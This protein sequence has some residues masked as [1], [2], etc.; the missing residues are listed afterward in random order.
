MKPSDQADGSG[1]PVAPQLPT[2]QNIGS[3]LRSHYERIAYSLWDVP[4]WSQPGGK[5]AKPG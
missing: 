3:L 4:V 2:R 5:D 1:G